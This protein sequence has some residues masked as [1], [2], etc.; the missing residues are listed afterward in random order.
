MAAERAEPDPAPVRVLWRLGP[1]AETQIDQLAADMAGDKPGREGY[2]EKAGRLRRA[3]ASA[4]MQVLR[5]MILLPAGPG[6][7]EYDPD[8]AP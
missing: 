2:L 6:H 7:P 3:R 4:D 1:E 5:E 8:E